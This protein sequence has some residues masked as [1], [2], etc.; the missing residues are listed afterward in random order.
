MDTPAPSPD[1][2]LAYFVCAA[3][4]LLE[5]T[6]V[7]LFTSDIPGGADKASLKFD[8][9]LRYQPLSAIAASLSGEGFRLALDQL[10]YYAHWITPEALPQRFDTRFFLSVLPPY[11]FP[12]PDGWELVDAVWI[13]PAE[14]IERTRAGTLTPH[15]ATLQHLKRMAP[16]ATLDELLEFARAK[17]VIP[18]LPPTREENGRHVPM[19]P[20]EI[21]G[22]W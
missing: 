16:Y 17:P 22:I 1:D 21:D 15:F 18:V 8:G 3:R 14:A 6:G 11:Q 4:E 7:V 9:P 5:E 19:I 13:E 2:S 10:V 12:R 20:S